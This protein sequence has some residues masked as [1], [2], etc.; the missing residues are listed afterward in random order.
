MRHY[1]IDGTNVVRQGH[2]AKRFPEVEERKTIDL[3]CRLNDLALPYTGRV[4]IDIFFD[5]PARPMVDVDPPVYIRFPID[6]YAD[7][8]IL[9]TARSLFAKGKGA[10]VVTGDGRLAEQ[11][12]EEGARILRFSELEARL[13][14]NRV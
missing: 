13:M 12:R 7:A 6:G 9:G 2:Y 10:V 11:L 8:A 14:E 3:L 4:R 1:L 5:G